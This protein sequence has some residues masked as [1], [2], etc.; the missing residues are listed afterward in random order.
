MI[1][2]L[3]SKE[4]NQA[5]LTME[6]TA[7]EF[8]KAVNE[9]YQA[10]KGKYAIDGFRK[11]KAPRKL[12]E[13]H[14]GE[15]VFFEDAINTMFSKA[16]P[17]ALDTLKLDVVD[18]PSAEFDKIEKGKGFTVTITVTVAPEFTVKDYKGV[19]VAKVEHNITDEDVN[20]EIETLQKRNSRLVLVD[21]PAQNGDTVLIDYAGFVGEEQFEGGTAE[22]QPLALGSNTFIPGFEE[23]LVGAKASEEKDVK[24]TFPEE[25]HSA[26]LA[27]KEAVFKC[28]VHEIK[29]MEQP[30]LNDEFAKDVSE[31]DTLEEL[32][33]D[34]R[35]KLE[36]A[37]ESKAEYETKN[38]VLEKVYEANEVDIPEVMVEDQIDE[39]M[40]EFD[41][42]L[43][44]Q[45]MDLQKY[46]EYLQK[47]PKDFREELRAD[48]YKKV[49]TRLIVE[50]VANAEK[51]EAT[52]EDVETELKAM[53]EQ[54]K[55]EIDKLREYMKAENY[56]LVAKD[57]K[58]RK[59][60][61]FMFENAIVE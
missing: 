52:D 33:K 43:R 16:Y 61:D 30:E 58:M 10:T 48:A 3:I 36:K 54:Y 38:A 2:T 14:Y 37:A 29:E 15:D 56:A 35:E 28:K 59:A 41:Q 44:Y 46:F 60:V 34:S 7:E 45:G 12:I 18:R 11:G 27:G 1:S 5:K 21:R 13:T 50:A 20:K 17:E 53:A 31:F 42:Q 39:M 47:D 4:K 57:I 23:Q 6:F 9:A 24:V 26:D 22:R 55:M 8:E 40:Q 25:Y 49:K 51:L 19:K 32:K